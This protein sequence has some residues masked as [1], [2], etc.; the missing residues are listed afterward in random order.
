LHSSNR[1]SFG[2]ITMQERAKNLNGQLE[3]V[4]HPGNGTRI[5]LTIP[6]DDCK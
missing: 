4:T 3:I 5:I 1:H 6:I 2:L